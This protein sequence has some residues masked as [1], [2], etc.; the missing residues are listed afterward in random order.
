MTADNICQIIYLAEKGGVHYRI[1][2]TDSEKLA[3]SAQ[4]PSIPFPFYQP[5][6]SRNISR[7]CGLLPLRAFLNKTRQTA[8]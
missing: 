3:N 1:C 8:R 6:P 7:L 4:P 2:H 5:S